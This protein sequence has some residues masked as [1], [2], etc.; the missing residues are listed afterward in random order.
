MVTNFRSRPG[1]AAASRA[2]P[3]FKQNFARSGFSSPQ[4]GQT[5]TTEV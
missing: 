5:D 1:T 2:V 4:F 3:Q